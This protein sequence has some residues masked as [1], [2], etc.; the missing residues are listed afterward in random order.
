LTS[1]DRG[2]SALRGAGDRGSPGT[3]GSGRVNEGSGAPVRLLELEF[4]I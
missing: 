2:G 4:I 1:G 3:R